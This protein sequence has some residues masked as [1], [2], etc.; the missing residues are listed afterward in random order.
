MQNHGLVLRLWPVCVL[1]D[2]S[3]LCYTITH[4]S[5][6]QKL[7]NDIVKLDFLNPLIES[8]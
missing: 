3:I 6:T 8:R 1:E 4:T 2:H 7:I 5:V